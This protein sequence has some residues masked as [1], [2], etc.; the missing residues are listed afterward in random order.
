MDTLV[1]WCMLSGI[2]S[3]KAVRC[4]SSAG[5]IARML[6]RYAFNS[7]YIPREG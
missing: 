7:G 1:V 5:S 6:A 4:S 3:A 2:E